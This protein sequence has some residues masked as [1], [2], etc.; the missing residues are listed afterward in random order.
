MASSAWDAIRKPIGRCLLLGEMGEQPAGAGEERDRLDHRRREVEVEEDGGNRHRHVHR[1][2]LA[3]GGVDGRLE[4]AG[5]VDVAA[6]DAFG[7]GEREDALGARIDRTVERD[8]RSRASCRRGRA[9]PRP[10]RSRPRRGPRRP[11]RASPRRPA[12]RRRAA[13]CRGS[14]C[15]SRGCRRR[16][17]PAAT[18]ARRRRSCARRSRSASAH[19]RRWRRAAGRGRSAAYRS[20]SFPV[21]RKKKNSVK[22]CRPIRSRE[23]SRPRI[24]MRSASARAERRFRLARL[25]DQHVISSVSATAS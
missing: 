18:P 6:G 8:G 12:R 23:R 2:R 16:A 22:V 9:C 10:S 7:I 19:A 1:Q 21:I 5:Q 13:P 11:R 3:P 24:T 25:A 17:R 20:A 4:A 15:R 14:P